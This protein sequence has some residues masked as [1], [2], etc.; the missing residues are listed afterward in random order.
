MSDE[1][2]HTPATPALKAPKKPPLLAFM[3]RDDQEFLPSALEILER[4]ASPI[5]LLL[6]VSICLFVLAALGWSYFGW[7]DIVAVAQGKIQ[8]SGRV[9]TVQPIEGG[10]ITHIQAVNGQK[11]AE[12]DVLLTLQ[13]N[14]AQ[15][16]VDAVTAQLIHGRAEALRRKAVVA[17]AINPNTPPTILWPDLIPPSVRAREESVLAADLANL[18]A[19]LASIDAQKN[20]K[21]AERNR[22]SETIS[23]QESLVTILGDRVDMRQALQQSAAGTKAS[24]IDALET[25]AYQR[26]FLATER[27]QLIEAERG[28]DA[29]AAERKRTLQAFIA[30]NATKGSDAQKLADEAEPRLTKAK[31]RVSNLMI[32]SPVA[33]TVQASSAINIGQVLNAG[34]EVMRI[35]PND[36]VLEVE[37]YLPNK[38]IGFVHEGQTAS[39][40]VE[41]FPF[42]RYG[43]IEATV[44]RVA[45]DAIPLPEA[46]A[47][48]G[49]TQPQQQDL[50]ASAGA[51]RV[52]N[53][54]FPVTLK[55]SQT[56][57]ITEG[58]SVPLA[59]GMAITA[60]IKTGQR[61]LLDYLLSPLKEVGST[62]VKER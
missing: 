26:T 24:L 39:V 11:V 49:E 7:T 48:E 8:P 44:T 33:G 17:S 10:K 19:Q 21:I 52:Q 47:A 13:D 60:E 2:L 59:P 16:D 53:L 41:A 4:P 50:K 55:L 42:T 30:D 28:I 54:Y 56:S 61:R 34:Q 29:L 15:A 51:Q 45:S 1:A 25:Q 32:R 18:S 38:D 5:A 3:T 35:V 14:E 23:A 31:I 46:L 37:T 12:G 58:K 40:K 62:A 9:K 43:T 20:Q 27:G 36:A 57:I 6:L 22:L